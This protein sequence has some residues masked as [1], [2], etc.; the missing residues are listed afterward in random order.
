MARPGAR[1]Y[2]TSLVDQQ[3]AVLARRDPGRDLRQVQAHGL[4]VA[5]RQP[6]SGGGAGFGADCSEDVGGRRALV[7]W[8][9]GTRAT[10]CPPPTDLV[11]LADPGFVAEPDLYVGDVDALI[12]SDL[13]QHGWEAFLKHS[14]APSACA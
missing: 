12:A 2:A 4:G 3:S 10:P 6:Q 8:C 5:P 9:R 11:L 1:T 7:L 14:M 13:V